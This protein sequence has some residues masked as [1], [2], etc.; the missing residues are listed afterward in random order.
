[1]R[2]RGEPSAAAFARD[3]AR[4]ISRTFQ[5]VKMIPEMTVL[6]NVALGGYLRGKSG[7]TRAML[8]LDREEERRLFAEAERQLARIGMADRMHE[9]AGNL[10]LGRS[11]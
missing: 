6:E 5:H 10:A 8:R 3:R 9:L 1:V 2:W 11:A 7:T 4:G